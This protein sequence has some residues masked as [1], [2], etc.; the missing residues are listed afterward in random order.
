[1]FVCDDIRPR[2]R[3]TVMTAL[4]IWLQPNDIFATVRGESAIA[5]VELQR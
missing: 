1:M 3:R 2:H 5:I 4:T